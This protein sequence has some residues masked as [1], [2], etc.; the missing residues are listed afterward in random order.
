M[1]TRYTR[2]VWSLEN[3]ELKKPEDDWVDLPNVWV[4]DAL[5]DAGYIAGG[6]TQPG[7]NI[8][9]YDKISYSTDTKSTLTA[10]LSGPYM[11]LAGASS[12]TAGYT[13]GGQLGA[14]SYDKKS[15]VDKLTFA[16]HTTAL[17]PGNFSDTRMYMAG[18]AGNSTAGYMCGGYNPDVSDI[19]KVTWATDTLETLP[20]N[21]SNPAGANYK[22]STTGNADTFLYLIGGS[23]GSGGE[24]KKFTYSSE[25]C[26]NVSEMPSPS[27][28][29]SQRGGCTSSSLAAYIVGGA[30]P[31]SSKIAKIT[32]SNDTTST[33]SNSTIP[34]PA[35]RFEVAGTGSPSAGYY[36]GGTETS[37]VEKITMSTEGVA[38]I[39]ALDLS[40]GIK[41][42]EGISAKED[43]RAAPNP[44]RWFDGDTGGTDTV[45]FDG[46]DDYLSI[47]GW[48][49]NA[50]FDAYAMTWECWV[51]FTGTNG[52]LETMWE[53]RSA[54]NEANGFLIGRFH[55][56]GH[57]N[58]IEM[59][60]DSDYRITTDVTVADNVWTHVA[61]SKDGHGA[62]ARIYINGTEAGSFTDGYNYSNT[63]TAYIGRNASNT[64]RMQGYI[65]NMRF[66]KGAS[67]YTSNFTVPTE[68]LTS[69]SQGATE[70]AG[71]TG[72]KL[73]MCNSPT[74]T[75]STVA[76]NSLSIS[77]SGFSSTDSSS[78]TGL[79]GGPPA[80]TPTAS[81][82]TLKSI[83]GVPNTGYFGGGDPGNNNSVKR[84]NFANETT[85]TIPAT[86]S[87]SREL[88]GGTS[89]ITYG[90][91]S[92]GRSPYY[93]IT[94]RV[95]YSNDTVGRIPGANT[96]TNIADC[97]GSG[98]RSY[99]ILGG[100]MSPT[101][102]NYAQKLSF[103]DETISN[104]GSLPEGRHAGAVVTEPE[105]AGYFMAGTTP[106]GSDRSSVDK[107]TF[108]TS[109]GSAYPANTLFA[110]GYQ[111]GM[112]SLTAGYV[113]GGPL[114]GGAG[115]TSVDKLTYSTSTWSTLSDTM[116]AG[117][118]LGGG[119]N[120]TL[121][122][123]FCG[124]LPSNPRTEKVTFATETVARIP[125]ADWA[126]NWY[127]INGAG[128]QMNSAY[129]TNPN[130]I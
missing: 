120:N 86:L 9:I 47:T 28:H 42:G 43:N 2:G 108:S 85:S 56:S 10:N 88:T 100:G 52:T 71:S 11:G 55:T 57:E 102:R 37:Y 26:A 113:S 87:Q 39:P 101:I 40:H 103:A 19:R 59:F 36:A 38:R 90:Y 13:M 15:T 129:A 77:S 32:F 81:T 130:V 79:F 61:Y 112:G 125:G 115:K 80:A 69:T 67:L 117:K 98:V 6:A 27:A 116:S 106:A 30:N 48:S 92:G 76:A 111:T 7:P 8:S 119:L 126:S 35:G 5:E 83:S 4:Q 63:G 60:T 109:T 93:S 73:I 12:P 68:P 74:I 31:Y 94:D 1:S 18:G 14:P 124:G 96:V 65:S 114:G 121:F 16:T 21:I 95:T 49:S 33:I 70:S 82:T 118:Y 45:F 128:A 75:G 23:S 34:T 64:H 46:S 104:D 51:K 127:R 17:V 66:V 58:K 53:N 84:F 78:Q 123:V 25:S 110:K 44:K 72:T 107:Y 122:G 89:S 20:A 41:R 105:T 3:V 22:Q 50:F 99:G 24:V 54:T 97:M 62:E 91:F 29:R